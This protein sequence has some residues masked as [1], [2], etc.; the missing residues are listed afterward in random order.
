MKIRIFAAVAALAAVPAA[1]QTPVQVPAFDSVELRGG[2]TVT[3]RHGA[4]QSV[5]LVSG[6][7]G[8]S[9]FDVDGE[10]RLTITACRD[11]CRDYRLRVEIVTPDI[12]GLGIRGGGSI[13]TEGDFPYRD[14][15][16]AGV[17]GGGNLDTSAIEA[18]TVT[19]GIQGGGSIRTHARDRLV[20]GI[21]GG[22]SVRY[23][24]DPQVT[25]GINGGGSV[26]P[27]R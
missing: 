3:I 16:A 23:L 8:T 21:Q 27:A 24:G 10:G 19:A 6:D 11:S 4:R 9:R 20:A 22:G 15:L 5:T 26:S 14:A 17:H 2:G 13:R 12:E 7:T 1:A 25:S 18:G